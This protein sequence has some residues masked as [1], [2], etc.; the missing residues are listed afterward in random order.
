LGAEFSQCL[1]RSAIR[2]ESH[3]EVY[4]DRC[5]RIPRLSD[6]SNSRSWYARSRSRVVARILM[7]AP[8]IPLARASA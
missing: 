2:G 7:L 6:G 1:A 4:H 5:Q 8:G 3:D